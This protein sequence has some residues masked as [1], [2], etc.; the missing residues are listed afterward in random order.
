MGLYGNLF[1]RGARH[2]TGDSPRAPGPSKP[3]PGA[4]GAT[5]ASLAWPRL[6][7]LDDAAEQGNLKLTGME[8]S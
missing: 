6:L 4:S 2:D 5:E 1:V 3:D 8:K 7:V